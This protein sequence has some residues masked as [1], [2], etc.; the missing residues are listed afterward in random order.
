MDLVLIVRDALASSLIGNMATAIGAR[1]AGKDVAVLFTGEALAAMARGSFAWPRELAGQGM[2]LT[3]AA[4]G[5]AAGLPV[6][7]RGE[8]RIV[9]AKAMVSRAQDAGVV[10]YACPTWAPL[11]GLADPL[12]GGLRGLESAAAI[13]LLTSAKTV[14]GTL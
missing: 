3:L 11:L 2:R 14:V 13:E 9:D 12:P 7:G 8:G 4:N 10:L 5:A 6:A 1:Q